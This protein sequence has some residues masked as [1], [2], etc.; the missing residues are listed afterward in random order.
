MD[1]KQLR[2]RIRKSVIVKDQ[3]GNSVVIGSNV[4]YG[5][6]KYGLEWG[7]GRKRVERPFIVL[8]S[9]HMPFYR[10]FSSDDTRAWPLSPGR[11]WVRRL[12]LAASFILVLALLVRS[13]CL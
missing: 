3:S 6:H 10:S 12:L 11:S 2:K 13:Y 7:D 8:Q 1:M 5:G 4:T 9:P